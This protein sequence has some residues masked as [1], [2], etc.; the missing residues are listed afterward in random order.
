MKKEYFIKALG[1]GEITLTPYVR[2]EN[3]DSHQNYSL[4]ENG[5]LLRIT[6]DNELYFDE[7]LI[8]ETDNGFIA[9]RSYRNKTDAVQHLC[10]LA[11]MLDGISFGCDKKQDF[12][13]HVE[14]PRIYEEMTFPI[15]YDRTHGSASDSEFDAQAGN[16]W[17]DPGVVSERI[18]SS[19][20]QPFPA[21]LVS[22]YS[23]KEGLVHGTLSQ[24]FFFHNYLLSH[25]ALGVRLEIFSSFKSV[26]YREIKPSETITDE[27]YIGRTDEA[28]NLEKIFEKYA[29]E[30]RKKLPANYGASYI[31][32]DNVVWGSWNDGIFRDVTEDILLA[33]A[34]ALKEHFPSVKWLQLDDGYSINK[35]CAH[36]LGV[37]YEGESGIDKEKFPKGLK[38]FT[39]KL[40]EIG[41][42]PAIWIGGACPRDMKISIE[43]PD[44]F[45]DFSER[46]KASKVL[47]VSLEEVKNY[48]L[49]AINKLC[50]E[51]G[52]D[53]VKHDFWSYAFESTG[54]YLKDRYASG[55]EHRSWWLREI[56]KRIP[57]DGYFQTGCDIVMGNPF[58]GEYFT[59]Y[60]Y[61]IDIG[62]GNWENIKTNFLWGTACFATHTGDLFVP[63]SDAI[64][65]FPGLTYTDAVFCIN[66]I[67]ITRSMV[68]LAG[69]FSSIDTENPRFKM[70]KKAVACPNN[71]DDVY[72]ARYDYRKPGRNTPEILYIKT[73][74]F[75]VENHDALPLRT[76]A[77]FNI[78]E[79]EKDVSFSLSE[80]GLEDGD[81][82]L[83]DVW[84]GEKI[85]ANGNC[86]FTLAPHE[87]RLFSVNLAK[88]IQIYDANFK[89]SKL[90]HDGTSLSFSADYACD[91][92]ICLSSRPTEICFGGEKIDFSE[93]KGLISFRIPGTGKIEIKG[94]K[95]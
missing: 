42:R 36:G 29:D 34:K 10:E 92:E 41:L 37:P 23:S 51:Y 60:R 74:H 2:F 45:C 89:I 91:A 78:D 43:H 9:K 11:T 40:R 87:S 59:N 12:F 79:N 76:L 95:K 75:S 35:N 46:L 8:T 55:Y 64:G 70:L 4:F 77:I 73:P 47:D 85:Q 30:L 67:L 65:M 33:E 54:D 39:D 83:S 49:F 71:G 50:A 58:L 66:Y 13:Y 80:L 18:G 27:W 52:F 1:L 31:N 81:Y 61:G 7:I 48:M 84:S 5:K 57:A 26:K 44:W 24:R 86:I 14:N 28:D 6:S 19:P 32:R 38:H 63:N 88:G 82:I 68:E 25:S 21:I 93:E 56:R 20:Y 15:D 72:L 17:A 53:A 62:V 90:S 16:K 3:S 69:K 22:N 94:D